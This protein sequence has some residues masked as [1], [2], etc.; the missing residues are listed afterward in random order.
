MYKKSS[1]NSL[2]DNAYD[3]I[4]ADESTLFFCGKNRYMHLYMLVVNTVLIAYYID[5]HFFIHVL[6]HVYPNL[7]KAVGD[8][9]CIEVTTCFF[10]R[11]YWNKTSLERTKIRLGL[12]GE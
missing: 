12:I 8:F 11:R 6:L 5:E 3:L 9:F 7:L 1:V 10:L 4:R 2:G